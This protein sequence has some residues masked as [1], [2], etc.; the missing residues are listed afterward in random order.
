MFF[1]YFQETLFKD[2]PAQKQYKIFDESANSCYRSYCEN[3]SIPDLAKR[4]ELVNLCKSIACRYTN[5]PYIVRSERKYS[6]RC[7]YF[8]HWAQDVIKK[9]FKVDS[10]SS[11]Y[12]HFIFKLIDVARE[13]SWEDLKSPPC[14][15]LFDSDFKH[16]EVEKDI[17]DYFKNIE[18]LKNKIDT[19]VDK[20]NSYLEYL[21]YIKGLYERNHSECCD[22]YDISYSNCPNYFVCNPKFHPNELIAKINPDSRVTRVTF[23]GQRGQTGSRGS[24]LQGKSSRYGTRNQ[25][26]YCPTGTTY[27]YKMNTCTTPDGLSF[28]A[29]DYG[30]DYDFA[31]LDN[32]ISSGDNTGMVVPGSNSEGSNTYRTFRL[33]FSAFLGLVIGVVFYLFIKVVRRERVKKLQKKLWLKFMR[34]NSWVEIMLM[35]MHSGM[36][37]LQMHS[38][39]DIMQMHSGMIIMQMHSGMIIMQMRSGMIIMEKDNGMTIMQMRTGM[40]IMEKDN[41]MTIMQMHSGMSIMQMHSGMTV[42][43]DIGMTIMEKVIGMIIMEKDIGMTIIGE[44]DLLIIPIHM[45]TID[46]YVSP[47]SHLMSPMTNAKRS[48]SCL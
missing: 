32:Q 4:I 15:R 11:Y 29:V 30:T 13:I 22:P 23:G 28:K 36:D 6:D 48:V 25:G 5:L 45:I 1:S 2:F 16:W 42:M 31:T 43:E 3:L 20:R 34:K 26:A 7:S 24:T 37:M 39:V 9:H 12:Y 47:I 27:D 14:Q 19:D 17:H 35:Q 10:A 38:G 46:N 8:I 33:G 44:E 41:G 18:T 21:T 40:I